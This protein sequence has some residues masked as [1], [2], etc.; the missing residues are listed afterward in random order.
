MRNKNKESVQEN[1]K[2]IVFLTT[3]MQINT[4]L[5]LL[6]RAA[7]DYKVPTL[8]LGS[9]EAAAALQPGFLCSALLG[10]M[11]DIFLKWFGADYGLVLI[12]S[13]QTP[14]TALICLWEE[15][16]DDEGDDEGPR[17]R[18]L[19]AKHLQIW[20]QTKCPRFLPFKL[21]TTGLWRSWAQLHESAHSDPEEQQLSEPAACS[22]PAALQPRE[23]ASQLIY[24]KI[25][26]TEHGSHSPTGPLQAGTIIN[27]YSRVEVFGDNFIIEEKCWMRIFL[28]LE[29][30]HWPLWPTSRKLW[31]SCQVSPRS[32]FRFGCRAAAQLCND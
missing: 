13:L 5:W 17:T 18:L 8:Q 3:C 21:E 24:M 25:K 4:D 32:V 11:T 9:V 30:K 28:L 26:S 31:P 2:R 12:T 29:E 6:D 14:Q 20:T 7:A 10:T 1:Q 16:E 19:W 15:E 22:S 23:T 27:C